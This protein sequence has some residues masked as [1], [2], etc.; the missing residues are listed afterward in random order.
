MS[1][2]NT[3]ISALPAATTAVG[4]EVAGVQDA[5]TKRLP[6]SVLHEGFHPGITALTGGGASALDGIATVGLTVPVLRT[7]WVSDELQDWLLLAGTTAEDGEGIVRPDDYAT[8]TNEK[9]WTR[10]R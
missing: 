8:S 5:T 7:V 4:F 10:V 6:L 1:T 9:I 3:K 2:A